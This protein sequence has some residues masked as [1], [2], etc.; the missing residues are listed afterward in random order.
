[1]QAH[2]TH[3]ST[4]IISDAVVCPPNS[5]R[6]KKKFE[7]KSNIRRKTTARYKGRTIFPPRINSKLMISKIARFIHSIKFPVTRNLIL[8]LPHNYNYYEA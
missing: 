1:M 6:Q 2:L 5:K 3:R 7:I 8:V 4:I